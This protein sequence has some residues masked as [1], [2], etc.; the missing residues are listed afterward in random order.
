MLL[1]S[2]LPDAGVNDTLAPLTARE[3]V[4]RLFPVSRTVKELVVTEAW[5]IGSLKVA[6]IGAVV[7]AFDAPLEGAVL[8]TDGGVVSGTFMVVNV[9]T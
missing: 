1:A 8:V 9:Q 4:A 7:E 2:G 5:L 6:T 3:P